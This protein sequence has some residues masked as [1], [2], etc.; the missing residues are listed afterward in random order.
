MTEIIVKQ[1]SKTLEIWIIGNWRGNFGSSESLGYLLNIY[2]VFS[3]PKQLNS[4]PCHSLT[5]RLNDWLTHWQ[6]PWGSEILGD[7]GAPP[8]LFSNVCAP[9]NIHW[10]LIFLKTLWFVDIIHDFTPMYIANWYSFLV[11]L[12]TFEPR[13]TF[14]PRAT[15]VQA[16]RALG[17][18]GHIRTACPRTACNNCLKMYV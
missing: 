4:W 11:R 9:T 16:R 6:T 10:K 5:D 8:P 18:E 2:T 12:Q 3:C 15:C 1:E 13:A 7:N 17:A 14:K